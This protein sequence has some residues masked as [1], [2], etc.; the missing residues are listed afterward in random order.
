M[1]FAAF[2]LFAIFST[3]STFFFKNLFFEQNLSCCACSRLAVG[4][5]DEDL[6]TDLKT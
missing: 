6:K 5:K 3:D 4:N 1:K 2:R